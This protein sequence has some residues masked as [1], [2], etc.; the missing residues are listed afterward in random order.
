MI[1]M[2]IAFRED[3]QGV[4]QALTQ[5]LVGKDCGFR[6]SVIPVE[7]NKDDDGNVVGK[8]DSHILANQSKISLAVT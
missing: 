5:W 7:E 3:K 2:F 6:V 4:P 8:G 1:V